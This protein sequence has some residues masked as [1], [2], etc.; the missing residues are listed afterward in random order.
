MEPDPLDPP[1]PQGQQRPLILEPAELAFHRPALAIQLLPA[2]RAPGD[3][4]VQSAGPDPPAGRGALARGVA[5]LGRPALGVGS[6]E[7][8]LAVL[9]DRRLVLAGLDGG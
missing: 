5:P 4:G 1:D 9:A 2:G 7:G 6:G 8:P 3:K